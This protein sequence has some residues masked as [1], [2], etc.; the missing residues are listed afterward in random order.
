MKLLFDEYQIQ[1]VVKE[2]AADINRDYEGRPL[3]V[4]GILN[5][6][7]I[8]TADLVQHLKNVREVGFIRISSY[9]GVNS[10]PLVI[11]HL[12]TVG[13]EGRDILVVEDIIDTG[14]TIAAVRKILRAARSVAVC[15]LIVRETLKDV[16]YQGFLVQKGFLYG[17]GLDLNGEHR[18]LRGIYRT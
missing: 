3:T 11:A 16:K 13:I 7:F 10:G 1:E 6:A 8:F 9:D 5:G 18:N 2:L 4:I 17:Y 12:P 15:S 14:K